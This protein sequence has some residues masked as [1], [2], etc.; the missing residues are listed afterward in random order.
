MT[1]V[2]DSYEV[3]SNETLNNADRDERRSRKRTEHET[4][5]IF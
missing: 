5:P 4:T 1:G 2:Q 3:D